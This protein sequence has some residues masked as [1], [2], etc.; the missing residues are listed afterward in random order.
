M[1][2][3]SRCRDSYGPSVEVLTCIRGNFSPSGFTC[4]YI[5]PREFTAGRWR[6][7][8][9]APPVAKLDS[10]VGAFRTKAFAQ[11]KVSELRDTSSVQLPVLRG[12]RSRES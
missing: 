3:R 4:E 11:A 7:S 8:V 5:F 1:L 12:D 2:P 6:G 9:Q 10:P